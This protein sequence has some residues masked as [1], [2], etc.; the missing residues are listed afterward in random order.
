MNGK[1]IALVAIV[2]VIL[3][4]A[5]VVAPVA[6]GLAFFSAQSGGAQTCGASNDAASTSD[7]TRV[8][9]GDT[10]P[11]GVPSDLIP[12]YQSAAAKYRL[13]DRGPSILAAIN[14]VET[15]YGTNLSTSTAGAVGWM[16]FMPGTW[17]TYG[18]DANGDGKKDPNDPKDA[19]YAA[20]KYLRASGA[21]RDW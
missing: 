11:A 2:A 21:P 19:I 16:Q 15:A 14:F 1:V 3:L 6:L 5:M 18:V 17:A 12:I 9:Q 4:L 13:G 10:N 8:N 20:A 7:Q